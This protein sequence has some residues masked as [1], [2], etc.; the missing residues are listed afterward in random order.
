[1]TTTT[2]GVEDLRGLFTSWELSLRA[3]RRA[4]GTLATY[5]K[6][7]DQ[8]LAWC[9]DND[10]D[11]LDRASVRAWVAQRLDD[12]TAPATVKSRLLAVRRFTA[13]LAEEGEIDTDPF[14]GIK[15]PKTDTEV[16]EP[17]TDEE[18]RALLDACKVPRGATPSETFRG[19]RDEALFRL[20]LESGLRAGEVLAITVDDVDLIAGTVVVRRGKGGKGRIVPFGPHTAKALDRYMRDR[21]KHRLA[22]TPALWLGDRGKGLAYG[23]LHWALNARADAAGVKGFHPHRMRHTAAHRWLAAGGSDSGLMAVA[24]WSSPVMLTRYTR[25][26]ATDRA[27]AESRNLNLGDL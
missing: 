12:G 14:L 15:A 5:Q 20:M 18:L 10:A 6:G 23:G 21:R 22:S 11:P 26:R 16:V 2:M 24:G 19:R 17:F 27:I 4:S 1:M 3:A 8:F 9:E 25:A 13:W 7:V